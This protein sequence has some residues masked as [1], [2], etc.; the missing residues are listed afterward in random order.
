MDRIAGWAGLTGGW[1]EEDVPHHGAVI[2]GAYVSAWCFRHLP[3]GAVKEY[4]D[5]LILVSRVHDGPHAGV[6]LRVESGVNDLRALRG[7]DLL[8]LGD[9][10]GVFVDSGHGGEQAAVFFGQDDRMGR[11]NRRVG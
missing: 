3:A 11:I 10:N 6:S 4:G 2:D 7:E 1:G 5:G 9:R 8:V